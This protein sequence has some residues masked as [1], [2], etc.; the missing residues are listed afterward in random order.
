MYFPSIHE[1]NIDLLLLKV[2]LNGCLKYDK[3]YL[4]GV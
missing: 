4:R 2:H 3:E 1:A